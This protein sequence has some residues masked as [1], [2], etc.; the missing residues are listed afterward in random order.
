MAEDRETPSTP[1]AWLRIEIMLKRLAAEDPVAHQLQTLYQ[2]YF[3][4]TGEDEPAVDIYVVLSEIQSFAHYMVR[5]CGHESGAR[6]SSWKLLINPLTNKP[7][8]F[9]DIGM[10]VDGIYD[11]TADVD[12]NEELVARTTLALIKVLLRCAPRLGIDTSDI[13]HALS[14]V[15]KRQVVDVPR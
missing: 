14:E 3:A 1:R 12:G 10:N 7:F 9:E 2:E 5:Y 4:Y 13:P 8:T 6:N 11:S 15:L